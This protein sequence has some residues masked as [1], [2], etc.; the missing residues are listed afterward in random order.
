MVN[1]PATLA[2]CLT[3]R[4]V[5]CPRPVMAGRRERRRPD[6][7]T[8]LC[9]TRRWTRLFRKF[10]GGAWERQAP[11]R[12]APSGT[13]PPAGRGG[14]GPFT[15]LRCHGSCEGSPAVT[16]PRRDLVSTRSLAAG[17]GFAL[18]LVTARSFCAPFCSLRALFLTLSSAL[19]LRVLAHFFGAFCEPGQRSRPNRKAS[20]GLRL[21]SAR[22]GGQAVGLPVARHTVWGRWCRAR[23]RQIW[24][25][26]GTA[27]AAGSLGLTGPPASMLGHR[28]CAAG[29]VGEDDLDRRLPQSRSPHGRHFFSLAW[30]LLEVPSAVRQSRS[31]WTTDRPPLPGWLSA[32]E[33]GR[34]PGAPSLNKRSGSQESEPQRGNRLFL[35]V[36]LEMLDT[37]LSLSACSIV[38]CQV[39]MNRL[40]IIR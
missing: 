9:E 7:A 29:H 3:G 18:G 14:P 34:A 31:P 10:T 12:G 24:R 5:R 16:N 36:L 1:S 35:N 8:P 22:P 6:E 27:P 32:A 30:N 23:S 17:R 21:S 28:G 4:V 15:P 40:W 11:P 33:L 37:H 20:L 19:F 13:T 25:S 2:V 38:L 39:E 26:T